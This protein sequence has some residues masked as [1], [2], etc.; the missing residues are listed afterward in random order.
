M[1]VRMWRKREHA[2]VAGEI[3][4]W[5]NSGNQSGSSSEEH[6]SYALTDK[7]ILAQ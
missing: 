3:A 1:L 7:W 2:S 6:T 4:N 5:Y